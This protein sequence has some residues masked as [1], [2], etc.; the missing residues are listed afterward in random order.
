MKRYN[1]KPCPL[2]GNCKSYRRSVKVDKQVV[3]PT[4]CAV[5]EKPQC[6]DDIWVC[7]GFGSRQKKDKR[8]KRRIKK[9]E[10]QFSY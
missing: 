3:G 7:E 1:F 9:W 8:M 6:I 5:D 4:K 10:R 2:C